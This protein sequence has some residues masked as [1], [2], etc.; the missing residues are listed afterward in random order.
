MWWFNITDTE[1]LLKKFPLFHG[2]TVVSEL[3]G[4]LLDEQGNPTVHVVIIHTELRV[5]LWHK[6]MPYMCPLPNV[7][8][9][10]WEGNQ[11]GINYN[12]NLSHLII[13]DQSEKAHLFAQSIYQYRRQMIAQPAITEIMGAVNSLQQSDCLKALNHLDNASEIEPFHP[14]HNLLAALILQ[15]VGKG[16]EA[17]DRLSII[18]P[19]ASGLFTQ[20][21][22]HALRSF[23]LQSIHF[24][25]ISNIWGIKEPLDNLSASQLLF[26]ALQSTRRG[27]SNEAMHCINLALNQVKG[28]II[29]TI[30]VLFNAI[31]CINPQQWPILV[32]NLV[33]SFND[34]AIV[35]DASTDQ[36]D[37][38]IK[39][40]EVIPSVFDLSDLRKAALS[41]IEWHKLLGANNIIYNKTL[42][43]LRHIEEWKQILN[44]VDNTNIPSSALESFE[45]DVDAF[46]KILDWFIIKYNSI[47]RIERTWAY[48]R[49][50]KVH[51]VLTSCTGDDPEIWYTQISVSYSHDNICVWLAGLVATEVCVRL[52]R[53]TMAERIL[54]DAYRNVTKVIG[55]LDDLYF[56]YA[57]E[58][59]GL[60][61]AIISNDFDGYRLYCQ[62]L[63]SEQIGFGWVQSVKMLSDNPELSD[64]EIIQDIGQ[65]TKFSEWLTAIQTNPIISNYTELTHTRKLFEEAKNSNILKVVIGGE[66]SSGKSSF[67]NALIG[68]P[69]LY[70]TQEEATAI[71]TIVSKGETWSATIRDKNKNVIDSIDVGMNLDIEQKQKITAFT[72]R[73][74]FLGSKDCCKDGY[75][76][77]TAPVESI[78][79]DVEYIDTPGL[80]ANEIRTRKAQDTIDSAHA[81]IFVLDA[82]NAL[83]A[84]EMN[85]IFWTADAVGKTLFIIN[86]MDRI[87]S[88][89]ELDVDDNAF[90]TVSTRVKNELSQALGVSELNLF[91]VTSLSEDKLIKIGASIEVVQYARAIVDVRESLRNIL[92]ESKTRLIA[93]S[94][95]KM[96]R[97]ITRL[98]LDQALHEVNK[99][100]KE[101]GQLAQKRPDDHESFSEYVINLTAETWIDAQGIYISN[102]IEALDKA[103]SRVNQR[104]VNGLNSCSSRDE[105]KSFVHCQITGIFNDFVNDVDQIRVHEWTTVGGIIMNEVATLFK[106]LYKDINFE[107][108][109][110]SYEMLQLATPMPLL[111]SV[112][113]LKSAI[114]FMLG[115]AALKEAGGCVLG[116]LIGSFIA[117]GVGTMIGALIGGAA[118]SS[119]N[120]DLIKKIY[121]EIMEHFNEIYQKV[122]TALDVDITGDDQN[123]P[124]IYQGILCNVERER[125]KY[126]TLIRDEII[127]LENQ[128]QQAA[129]SAAESRALA[130]QASA[131]SYKLDQF[132]MFIK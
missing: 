97:I 92:K 131:W 6:E 11:F 50:D 73:Y 76:H 58:L 55:K 52:N 96:A 45:H 23:P 16:K 77:I 130:K 107:A 14:G 32:E 122:V 94:A 30:L 126:D 80:N 98:A 37:V 72:E 71:P 31:E 46:Q 74:T 91:M 105:L 125:L 116:A 9:I 115:G 89:D 51:D 81:C 108:Q 129:Q 38:L 112:Q 4:N 21:V 18:A 43:Y 120:D 60:Y 70:V 44:N 65:I 59:Y 124:P 61:S 127:R 53:L 121:D 8:L 64:K 1:R 2:E 34:L 84:G 83:K 26:V 90:E 118:G 101:I 39:S 119:S 10:Q 56:R 22:F 5:G 99:Y 19:I 12:N 13:A 86:K 111:E 48:L 66:T 54:N 85:K 102:M 106:T 82:A 87:T 3:A 117:P 113:G 75:F 104:I 28:D 68:Y 63:L 27:E 41:G 29:S 40:A 25:H 7:K 57:S 132:I 114:N 100:E 103:A 69:I 110:N 123:Y 36:K 78:P 15:Y 67:I 128:R 42:G 17:A 24:Y 79:Y 62:L 109:F 49:L 33:S 93:F 95:A 20:N 47:N 88:D 35:S